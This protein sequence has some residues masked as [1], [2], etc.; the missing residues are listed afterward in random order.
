MGSSV[1]TCPKSARQ[2]ESLPRL[3][4]SKILQCA[5]SARSLQG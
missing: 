2:D 4:Q 1:P 3:T 5:A